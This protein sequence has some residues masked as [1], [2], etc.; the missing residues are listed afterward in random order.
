MFPI[1]GL[2]GALLEVLLFS[3][4]VYFIRYNN[5]ELM[6]L[7]SLTY[8]WFCFTILTGIWEIFYLTSRNKVCH[9]AQELIDDKKHIWTNRYDISLLL[10][11]KFSQVFYAEYGAYADRVYM[12]KKGLWSRLI[13]G[14]HFWLCGSF[15]LMAL[16]I[17]MITDAHSI[18]YWLL[19][20][21]SMGCQLMNSLLYMG[22]YQIQV[23]DKNSCNYN[24]DEFPTGFWWNKRP[25]MYVNLLWT[26]MP[27]IVMLLHILSP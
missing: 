1:S 5:V 20:G 24:S 3:I 9:M 14:S 16:I 10:P 18:S 2:V 23:H 6:T 27:V 22:E 12:A 4:S 11:W 25:F 21:F 7:N 8:Y 26:I 19:I 13:E 17:A 15:C